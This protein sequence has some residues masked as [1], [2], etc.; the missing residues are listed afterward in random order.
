M[1]IAI[2]TCYGRFELSRKARYLLKEKGFTSTRRSC[3][4]LER[5][6]P[7]LI[8]VIEKLGAEASFPTD[9]I[10]IVEIPDDVK[11][12]YIDEYDGMETIKE[13]RCWKGSSD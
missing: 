12:W 7:K 3:P 4:E 11:D 9:E 1:K 2:H 10:K 6:D 5:N 8:E 13:G